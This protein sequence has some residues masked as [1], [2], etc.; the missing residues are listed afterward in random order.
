[1]PLCKVGNCDRDAVTRGWCP[2]HYKRWLRH[3]DPL[4]GAKPQRRRCTV[5]DCPHAAEARGLCHGHL[6]R[7][8]RTGDWPLDLL[9]SR[10]RSFC[11]VLDCDRWAHANSVCPTHYRRLIKHGDLRADEPVKTALGIGFLNHGYRIVPIPRELRHLTNG[12]TPA[13]E[14]R[15]VM[16]MHLG[17][18]LEREEVVHHRNGV[19]T[20]NRIENLELWSKAQPS[21][22]RIEDKV[23]F[24]LDLLRR[25]RPELLAE[26]MTPPIPSQVAPTEFESAFPA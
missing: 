17:R 2:A 8:L 26:S 16:A 18:S 1:M 20:D 5:V 6:L 15:L 4:L 11:S 22:Q 3:G 25:Y 14:H 23:Q 10:K 21:G 19:R 13:E 24:A 12:K 7:L 9:S